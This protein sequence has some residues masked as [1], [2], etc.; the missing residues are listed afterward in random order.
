M[1]TRFIVAFLGLLLSACDG[2]AELH[3]LENSD[4]SATLSMDAPDFIQDGRMVDIEQTDLQVSVNGGEVDMS[5][6][7]TGQWVGSTMLEPG[8]SYT[9]SASWFERFENTQL[10]LARARKTFSIPM[11]APSS[12][13]SIPDNLYTTNFDVDGDERSNLSERKLDTNPLDPFSPG[14]PVQKVRLD[15]TF[16]LPRELENA[17]LEVTQ[18]LVM[19]A[20]INDSVFFIT[21]NANLWTGT[22]VAPLNN[23]QFI[24]ATLYATSARNEIVGRIQLR[25]ANVNAS[26]STVVLTADAYD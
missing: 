7:D 23:D 25:I 12:S 13:V 22:V 16:P 21:R 24:D 11:N 19:V 9:V 17:G 5:R 4:G 6:S 15:V 3:I 1:T 2:S 14:G 10:E 18:P 20:T 8:A 26:G